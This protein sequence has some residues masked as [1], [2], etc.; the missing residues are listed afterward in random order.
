MKYTY[1]FSK[2]K[3]KKMVGHIM[4]LISRTHYSCERNEYIFIV[5]RD[6]E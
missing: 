4:N 2:K 1:L 3:K 5:L 6:T